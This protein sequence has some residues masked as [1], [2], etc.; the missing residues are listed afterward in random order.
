MSLFYKYT[1]Y[2]QLIFDFITRILYYNLH[3][4]IRF[5]HLKRNHLI[6]A[7]SKTTIPNTHL[8]FEFTLKTDSQNRTT[9]KSH[10]SKST[11]DLDTC[12]FFRKSNVLKR[13]FC[14]II[15]PSMHFS[16]MF[17][18]YH[19]IFINVIFRN[20][21]KYNIQASFEI[22]Q[23]IRSDLSE[24]F[25]FELQRFPKFR[26]FLNF[27]LDQ[28]PNFQ[29]TSDMMR[30]MLVLAAGPELYAILDRPELDHGPT[31]YRTALPRREFPA[32]TALHRTN[33]QL[34][35]RKEAST[36]VPSAVLY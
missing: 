3:N 22:I 7:H 16:L 29:N 14:I 18:T 6:T 17:R 34:H 12:K 25:I 21:W 23:N 13:H 15:Y 36:L 2:F 26:N 24:T 9:T 35:I 28:R 31:P 8:N 30:P 27:F 10:M 33:K 5:Q 20:H 32:K 19:I 4:R 1:L 11:T